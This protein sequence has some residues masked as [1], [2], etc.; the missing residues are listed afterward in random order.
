[1]T[2]RLSYSD[3]HINSATL[4][5]FFVL[6][7][8]FMCD[9]EID[10]ALFSNIGTIGDTSFPVVSSER[11]FNASNRNPLDSVNGIGLLAAELLRHIA[12]NDGKT[13]SPSPS[14]ATS[15]SCGYQ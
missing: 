1:M 2:E 3:R 8:Q 9:S 11:P 10:F 12:D 5:E 4:R 13:V 14:D 6:V 7:A 15:A